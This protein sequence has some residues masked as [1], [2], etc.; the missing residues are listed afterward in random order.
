M[1]SI[2]APAALGATFIVKRE[3][4]AAGNIKRV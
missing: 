4:L 2:L 1:L 3:I